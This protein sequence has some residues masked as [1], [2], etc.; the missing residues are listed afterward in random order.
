LDNGWWGVKEALTFRYD[1]N[2]WTHANLGVEQESETS[3]MI[4]AHRQLTNSNRMAQEVWIK[5]LLQLPDV[6]AVELKSNLI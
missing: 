3:N 5:D 6:S 1:Q 4:Q 2:D